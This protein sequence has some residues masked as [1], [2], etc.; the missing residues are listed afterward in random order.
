MDEVFM[1]REIGVYVHIPFCKSRCRYCDFYSTTLLERRHDYI[2]ALICE[3]QARIEK[4]TRVRTIYLGGGTP[5]VMAVPEIERLLQ[6]IT[7]RSSITPIEVTME[8]NPGDLNREKLRAIK[9]AGV[10]RLSIGIQ[11]LDDDL[12]T[13]IGRRHSADEARQVIHDARAE[14]YE[15]ISVDLMYAL[16]TQTL[17]QW[18]KTIDEV[19]SWNVEHISAYCLS[20]EEGTQ[21]WHQ[22]VTGQITETDE[23]TV[24]NMAEVLR[25]KLNANGYVHY[26]VS[27]FAKETKRAIHNSGYWNNIPYI[28]IGTAAHSYDGIS[29]QW[30]VSDLEQ[31]IDDS[32]KRQLHPEKEILTEEDKHLERVM[33]GLRTCEGVLSSEVNKIKKEE[34]IRRGMLREENGRVIVT[35][36]GIQLL[37]IIIED[38]L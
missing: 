17:E 13:L 20:Y 16:P 33:L 29:R 36:K 6:I 32:I 35:D 4:G 10:N 11:S 18:E 38:L 7:S 2:E 24:N 37:N 3:A 9:Q 26:E 8:A 15:N 27:N 25:K 23:D 34:Y 14:N 22:R 5:S 31:Y 19:I 28:G 12:L 30:N 1:E 21:L